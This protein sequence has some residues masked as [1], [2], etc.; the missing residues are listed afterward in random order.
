MTELLISTLA[1]ALQ[2]FA[3]SIISGKVYDWI[4]GDADLQTRMSNCFDKAERMN[5]AI[6]E[7]K[8]IGRGYGNSNRFRTAIL[9]L[10]G[11]LDIC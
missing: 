1:S 11:G 7:I 6:Q 10:Y 4:K 5:E 8:T 3:I 9:F 2:Y